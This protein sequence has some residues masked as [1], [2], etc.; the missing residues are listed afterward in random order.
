MT[1]ANQPRSPRT[2]PV[3][4]V[5]GESPRMRKVWS[6]VERVAPTDLT[7]LVTGESGTGKE[8]VSRYIHEM[9]RRSRRPMITVD[10]ASIPP[11]L[12][13]SEL[14]GHTRGAFTGATESRMGLVARADGGTFFLDEIGEL[15]PEVQTRLLRLLQEGEYRP[16]GDNEVRTVDI[17]VIAATNRNLKGLISKGAFREDLYHR[18]NVLHVYVPPLRARRSDIPVLFQHFVDQ[19]ARKAGREPLVVSPELL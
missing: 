16:I 1:Q 5:I 2:G 10:C 19:V 8:V 13:E 14:F 4:H 9:S 17:R 11:G 6:L 18:L 3:P 15:A 7:V 12:M